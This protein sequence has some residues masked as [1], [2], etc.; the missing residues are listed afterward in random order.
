MSSIARIDR[1]HSALEGA[2]L[3]RLGRVG[4]IH[5]RSASTEVTSFASSSSFIRKLDQ[6]LQLF[7]RRP[8]F[9]D[10]PRQLKAI[11]DRLRPSSRD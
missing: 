10:S 4:V 1:A 7:H 3:A 2:R 8:A 5:P 11:L 6:P 9:N